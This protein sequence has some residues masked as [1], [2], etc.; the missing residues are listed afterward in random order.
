MLIWYSYLANK[1]D[2]QAL[3]R[4]IIVFKYA[5]EFDARPDGVSIKNSCISS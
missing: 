3:Q 5:R 2:K 4:A 1:I